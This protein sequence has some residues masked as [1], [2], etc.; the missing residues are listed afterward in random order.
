MDVGIQESGFELQFEPK[1]RLINQSD[2]YADTIIDAI[3]AGGDHY[4]QFTAL[5]YKSGSYTPMWPFGALGV[6]GVI[7]RLHSDLAQAFVLTSTT[8]TPAVATPATLTAS[9]ALLA[10]N[11]N[12]RLLF[13]TS[14]RK[15]PIR[16]RLYPY[17]SGAGVIKVFTQT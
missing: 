7:G 10:A 1:E 2:A 4:L 17:D 15:V 8:G 9:K 5:G 12:P 6:F 16:L 13:D 11:S 14:L 3:Y